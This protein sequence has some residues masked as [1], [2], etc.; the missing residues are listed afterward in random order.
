VDGAS[1]KR[2]GGWL[3]SGS[4]KAVLKTWPDQAK[5]LLEFE[6]PNAYLRHLLE[7]ECR[8]SA[9]PVW[10][11]RIG[12][13]GTA[14]EIIGRVVRP[15]NDYIVVTTRDLP[16]QHAFVSACTINCAGAKAFKLSIPA[17]VNA[18]DTHWLH[19]L[20]LQIARTVRI[21]PAGLPG[22]NWDGEGSGEW[23]TTEQPCLGIMHDHPVEAYT[24]RLDQSG[25][26]IISAGNPGRPIYLK[27]PALP[28]GTHLLTVKVRRSG[29]LDG[30]ASTPPEGHLQLKVREPEPWIPGVVS[31]SGMLVRIDP[32]DASLD[33]FWKNDIALSILGPQGHTVTSSVH[34][35][36]ADGTETFSEHFRTPMELPVTPEAWSKRFAQFVKREDCAWKFLEAASGRLI[37]NGDA[38]GEASLRFE[39]ELPPLRWV[40]RHEHGN[41]ILRLVDETGEEGEGPLVVFYSMQHPL[42][43]EVCAPEA[44]RTGLTVKPPGGMFWA[45]R[46]HQTDLVA[47]STGLTG[48]GLQGLG[49]DPAVDEIAT[50]SLNLAAA[51]KLL[52]L[53]WNARLAGFL[54]DSRSQKV[55][56]RIVTGIFEYICGVRWASVELA[57][58]QNP[59]S[60]ETNENLT[61]AVD[62][63][64]PG[65]AAVLHRDHGAMN[66]DF[67]RA[68][69]WFIKLAARHQ[70]C[71]DPELCIF[72]IKLAGA[73]QRIQDAYGANLDHML[74]EVVATPAILRGARLLALLWAQR[75]SIDGTTLLPR[76]RW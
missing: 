22:R 45:Q 17:A 52:A 50:A 2:P 74:D 44:C 40:L 42:W 5:P 72:A 43:L 13:D 29:A 26:Q 33:M 10:L 61:R 73:P 62:S 76:W 36:G 11:F 24:L 41:V 35:E 67:R 69:D 1:D 18:E 63:R 57:Y 32:P 55:K 34:L 19:K 58:R 47:V 14:L 23:L 9:G 25:E 49:V 30:I 70:V 37:I 51:C 20:G 31:H 8:L 75:Q 15:G 3:L 7:S 16:A 66:N 71:D 38:L 53:W 6:Q 56:D 27:L 21:W 39:H 65:F 64:H 4:R 12:P 48:D 59:G 54:A 60:K 46:G 68:S 28:V